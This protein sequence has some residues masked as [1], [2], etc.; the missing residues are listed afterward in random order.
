ML[1]QVMLRSRPRSCVMVNLPEGVLKTGISP[2]IYP[3]HL[4]RHDRMFDHLGP[5]SNGDEVLTIS[6]KCFPAESLVLKQPFL[7]F[8]G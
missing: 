3:R 8:V 5:S 6:I 1:C 7:S 2:E 4:S